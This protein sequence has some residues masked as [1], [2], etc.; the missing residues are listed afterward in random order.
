[1]VEKLFVTIAEIILTTAVS[2]LSCS[3]F[4]TSAAAYI[5]MATEKALITKILLITGKGTFNT[6]CGEFIQWCF[7]DI[8]QSP[9][10]LDKKLAAKGIAAVFDDDEAG[11][12]LTVCANGMFA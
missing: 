8:A 6:A 2:V 1:M 12:L 3:I 7:H 4:H 10:R 9:L 11:A 5:E